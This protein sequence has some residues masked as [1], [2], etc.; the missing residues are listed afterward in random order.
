[1]LSLRFTASVAL[2]SHT[3]WSSCSTS[4]PSSSLCSHV[5]TI[6]SA[7]AADMAIWPSRR[8]HMP[9]SQSPSFSPL[10][11]IWRVEASDTF[12]HVPITLDSL[13]GNSSIGICAEPVGL[14]IRTV[15]RLRR[16][17]RSPTVYRD[18]KEAIHG[19]FESG[20]VRISIQHCADSIGRGPVCRRAARVAASRGLTG[21]DDAPLTV[22]VSTRA[23]GF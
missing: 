3:K 11:G 1:M 6:A 19:G 16:L 7:A 12:I 8:G 20:V 9:P 15:R 22:R 23:N 17:P 10:G 13:N 14:R 2:L 21:R 4:C 5:V 18:I